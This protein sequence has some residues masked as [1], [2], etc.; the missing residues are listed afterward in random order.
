MR[1]RAAK[2]WR[3]RPSPPPKETA[4]VRAA[5]E[6]LRWLPRVLAW[7]NNTGATRYKDNDGGEQF[8]RFGVPGQADITGVL[9][10]WGIRLELE[11]KRPGAA[12]TSAQIQF[13]RLIE[14]RG[15]HYLLAHSGTEAVEL[16]QRLLA[17]LDAILGCAPQ[18]P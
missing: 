13:Q 15:G 11:L 12:Q 17:T 2:V 6:G 10:P 18:S 3:L 16:V 4:I 8:V 1:A 14:S 5:L 9:A 7:R